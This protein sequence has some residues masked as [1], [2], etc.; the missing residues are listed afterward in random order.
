MHLTP[1]E[2]NITSQLPDSQPQD[3]PSNS[4]KSPFAKR[5]PVSLALQG[6]DGKTAMEIASDPQI[7]ELLR[8][9]AKAAT[10]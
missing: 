4:R 7:H 1:S 8:E 9:P 10:F 6:Q 2:L 3:F 5:Q